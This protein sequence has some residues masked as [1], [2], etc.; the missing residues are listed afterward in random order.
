MV[1]NIY[2]KSID[3]NNLGKKQ[4]QKSNAVVGKNNKLNKIVTN[5]LLVNEA[6]LEESDRNLLKIMKDFANDM[7]DNT[8]NAL[9]NEVFVQ[10]Q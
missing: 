2:Q 8:Y 3:S 9:I 6:T 4:R 5:E 7:L 1:N 10:I